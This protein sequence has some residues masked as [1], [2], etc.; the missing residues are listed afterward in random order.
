MAQI[1][2]AVGTGAISEVGTGFFQTNGATAQTRGYVLSNW[3]GC[4]VGFTISFPTGHVPDAVVVVGGEGEVSI[5]GQNVSFNLADDAT[6]QIV[7]NV[8]ANAAAGNLA[9]VET[10]FTTPHGTFAG[11]E[12]SR[13]GAQRQVVLGRYL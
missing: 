10:E 6:V 5:A 13:A 9:V 1:I 12:S 3:T 11:A 4:K 7:T 8:A 2:G